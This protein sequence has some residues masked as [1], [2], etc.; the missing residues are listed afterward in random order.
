MK[1]HTK[2]LLIALGLGT[3]FSFL[4]GFS[5]V[6]TLVLFM[7]TV[8]GFV[9]VYVRRPANRALGLTHRNLGG[10]YQSGGRLSNV[11]NNPHAKG[12]GGADSTSINISG[13]NGGG[14]FGQ[15][16]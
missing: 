1:G 5:F 10:G 12:S 7:A 4:S 15:S 11:A 6:L 14:F 8:I 9:E 2:W 16:R 13:A 3:V